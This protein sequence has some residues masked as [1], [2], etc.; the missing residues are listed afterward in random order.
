MDRRAAA[1][2]GTF[3]VLHRGHE[4]LLRAAL[5]ARPHL[6]VGLATDAFAARRKK[7]PRPYP[8]RERSLGALLER[9]GGSWEIAELD[10]EF[11]PAALS[12]RVDALVVSEETAG[13]G[14]RLNC[15]RAR[16]GLGPVETVVVPMARAHDGDRISGTRVRRGEI[17]ADGGP[18]A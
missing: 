5:A 17:S 8:Q 13:A 14:E 4:Q 3:D 11:G 7:S 9:L 18:P 10:D 16:L 12:P 6:I 2:G 1:V 15:L